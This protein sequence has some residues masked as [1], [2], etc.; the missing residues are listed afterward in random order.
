MMK[1][2]GSCLRNHARDIGKCLDGADAS[3]RAAICD[4]AL[5]MLPW[6]QR[7]ARSR[8]NSAQA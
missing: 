3:L 2:V 4:Q 7:P 6:Y 1:R 5:T 8:F